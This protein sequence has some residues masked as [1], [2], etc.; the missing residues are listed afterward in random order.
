M[1]ADF[2]YSG[3]SKTIYSTADPGVVLLEYRDDVTAFNGL[4]KAVLARKGIVNNYFNAA[5]MDALAKQGIA[6]H[7][8]KRLSANTS[9]VKRLD[10]LPV[11]C[12]VRNIAA[13]NMSKRLGIVEGTILSAPVL[14]F[15]LKNDALDDPTINESHIQV[16]NWA[17]T[18]EIAELKK[19]SLKINK[20]LRVFF[21][22][23]GLLL[24]DFKLEFGRAEGQLWLGDE[25]TLDSARVWDADT[26][27]KFD[28][29]RFR[30]D[31]GNVIEFYEL[32]AQRLGIQIP[33]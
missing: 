23:A 26:Q 9:L 10:M 29:D 11:E 8:V 25:F 6:T 33:Q 12:V 22:Q 18:P 17:S 30:R 13:G 1:K 27:E 21:L 4:K 24:V 3:K 14:E 32:A 2:L 28:K 5:I 31:L 7:F 15:F 16:F 20:I 19:V